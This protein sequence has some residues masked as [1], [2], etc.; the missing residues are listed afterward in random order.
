MKEEFDKE[1]IFG[2]GNLNEAYAKYFIGNSYLNPLENS[3]YLHMCNVTFEPNCRNNWHIHNSKYPVG[4]VLICTAGKGVYEEWGK[5][6][7]IMTPGTVVEVPS[8]VKHFH[9]SYPGCW[10]SHIA[11]SIPGDDA[12]TEWLEEVND[13]EYYKI[14]K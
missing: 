12:K 7:I 9:G 2:K 6:P 5:E 14:K 1:N 3:N 11:F 4:Q 13:E 10:F 8:G